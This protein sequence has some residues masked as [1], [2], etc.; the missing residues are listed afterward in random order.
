MAD[1]ERTREILRNLYNSVVQFEED[2]AAKW[3]ATAAEEGIDP[4]VAAMK[5]LPAGMIEVRRKV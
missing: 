3:S 2:D 5:G 1:E 4:F